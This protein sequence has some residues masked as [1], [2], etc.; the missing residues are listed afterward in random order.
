[1]PLLGAEPDAERPALPLCDRPG[2][3]LLTQVCLKINTVLRIRNVYPGSEYTVILNFNTKVCTKLT[4]VYPVSRD[5][6]PDFFHPGSRIRS[7]D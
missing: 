5:P 4:D 7:T 1:L 6:E 2:C 3:S